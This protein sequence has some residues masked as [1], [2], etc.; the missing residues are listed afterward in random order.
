VQFSTRFWAGYA[1]TFFATLVT[2]PLDT[3]RVRI[4]VMH[5]EMSTPSMIRSVLESGGLRTLYQGFGATLIGAGPRGA[6]GFGVFETLKE[7][8]EKRNLLADFPTT[9]KLLIGYFAGLCSETAI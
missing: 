2:H 3:L 8:S 5:G 6:V 4:S 9:R 7:V 1:T